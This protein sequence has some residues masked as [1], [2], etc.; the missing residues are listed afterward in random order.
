[1]VAPAALHLSRGNGRRNCRAYR[2]CHSFWDATRTN[3]VP[4]HSEREI[5]DLV[6]EHY[7]SQAPMTSIP[8]FDGYE[9]ALER[10][11]ASITGDA[12][13]FIR[14]G[15]LLRYGV[16][17]QWPT[18]FTCYDRMMLLTDGNPEFEIEWQPIVHEGRVLRES[19]WHIR[20]SGGQRPIW[21]THRFAGQTSW[22]GMQ[23]IPFR[24]PIYLDEVWIHDFDEQVFEANCARTPR[25]IVRG[26]P[27]ERDGVMNGTLALVGSGE[28]LPTMERVD[29]WL[30]DRVP[31]VP[32]R[33]P[34]THRL[35][36]LWGRVESDT[37][38]TSEPSISPGWASR[39]IR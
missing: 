11:G 27:L 16:A 38:S 7:R 36:P 37:G 17:I 6:I 13:P 14:L 19:S 25:T 12:P 15:T 21:E 23:R 18:D 24:S 32:P 31:G 9:D 39:S 10:V 22:E 35:R 26:Q 33:R 4:T 30:L 8:V 2:C 28:Y 3:Y 34:V 20:I 29:R 1:M 5:M